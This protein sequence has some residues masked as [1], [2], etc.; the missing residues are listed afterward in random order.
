[1]VHHRLSGRRGEH[2]HEASYSIHH[3]VMS[4]GIEG[5]FKIKFE[6]DFTGLEVLQ[7]EASCMNG[8][9][10]SLWSAIAQLMR[11]QE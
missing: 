9:F 1:M 7:K 3:L 10:C 5:V 11:C 4:D 6:D 8:F 2:W